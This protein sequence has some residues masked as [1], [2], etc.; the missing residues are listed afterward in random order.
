MLNKVFLAYQAL[1]IDFKNRPTYLMACKE[2]QIFVDFNNFLR[3]NIFKSH[4][5]HKLFSLLSSIDWFHKIGPR[6]F[7]TR[8]ESRFFFDIDNFLRVNI[9]LRHMQQ[10][11]F[12]LKCSFD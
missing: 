12:S 9:L 5:E 1:S 11:L 6:A 2:S 10:T 7:K 3:V 8:L 4:K